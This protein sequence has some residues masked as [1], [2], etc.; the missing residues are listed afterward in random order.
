MN[1]YAQ[2]GLINDPFNKFE[3]PTFSITTDKDTF[4]GPDSVLGT[5]HKV[6]NTDLAFHGVLEVEG[7]TGDTTITYFMLVKLANGTY[8]RLPIFNGSGTQFSSLIQVADGANQ[9]IHFPNNVMNGRN[10]VLE[11]TNAI[12]SARV[13][14][15]A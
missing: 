10:L 3:N 15:K 5:S 8:S 2:R 14:L 4:E 11:A 6:I 7:I 9:I 12:S 13:Q 1:Q